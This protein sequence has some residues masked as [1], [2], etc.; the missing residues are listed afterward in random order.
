[1][2]NVSPD[3]TG[4]TKLSEDDDSKLPIILGAVFGVL[5][6]V[7]IIG[8]LLFR[9]HLVQ[10][11]KV[12]HHDVRENQNTTT[13]QNTTYQG[14]VANNMSRPGT[15]GNAAPVQARHSAGKII[16]FNI[17]KLFHAKKSSYSIVYSSSGASGGGSGGVR[18]TAQLPNID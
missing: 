7:A 4:I 14:P 1:M 10:Q 13:A 16:D 11:T 15:P 8:V 3:E 5:V 6:I 2:T 18:Q 12:S 9:R 17:S